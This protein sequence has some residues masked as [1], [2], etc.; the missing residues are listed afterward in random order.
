M[1]RSW[2]GRLR[3]AILSLPVTAEQ[4]CLP[5]SINDGG[6]SSKV[7]QSDFSRASS[8]R[9]STLHYG[10]DVHWAF[11]LPNQKVSVCCRLSMP[12]PDILQR[13]RQRL[14]PDAAV[15]V[16]G[17]LRKDKLIAIVLLS[18]HAVSAQQTGPP[19]RRFNNKNPVI[20]RRPSGIRMCKAIEL[21]PYQT[22]RSLREPESTHR[23]CRRRQESHFK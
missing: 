3:H 10:R 1:R 6:S 8:N 4:G 17:V 19:S 9:R 5:R 11:P 18:Q 21:A 15:N 20:T 14:Q 16:A 2:S 12:L 23:F 22:L 13:L 7:W